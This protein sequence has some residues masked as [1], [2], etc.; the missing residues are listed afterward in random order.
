MSQNN[1]DVVSTERISVPNALTEDSVLEFA[2]VLEALRPQDHFVVDLSSVGHVEPFGML[3][4]SSILRRFVRQQKERATTFSAAGHLENPYAAHMGFYQAFGLDHGKKPGEAPGGQNYLP[5]TCLSVNDLYKEAG[6][7][8]V[9]EAIERETARIARVLLQRSDG[10]ADSRVQYAL[11]EMFRNVVEH[12]HAD[13]I[14]YAGQCWPNR[15]C[16]EVAILDEGI[17]IRSS[18]GRKPKYR[19]RT[20]EEALRLAIQKGVSGAVVDPDAGRA[21]DSDDTWTNAGYG[22]YIVSNLCRTAGVFSIMSGGS[23][24]SVQNNE[25]STRPTKFLGTAV[26]MKLNTARPE[27][28]DDAIKNIIPDEAANRRGKSRLPG[29]SR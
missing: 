2:N 10:T 6:Y 13:E 25:M 18:L 15:D 19:V 21:A 22:L 23:C 7:R 9:G 8:P 27:Q 24:L 20:D 4:C 14:W 1:E 28:I 5:I 16:V 29:G 3:V 26:R 12:S 11:T 17:G